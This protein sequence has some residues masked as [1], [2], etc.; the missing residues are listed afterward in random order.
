MK[1]RLLI[2]RFFQ[3]TGSS[4]DGC[5]TQRGEQP[6][7]A[8]FNPRCSFL[9]FNC[10]MSDTL[11]LG[12]GY[13]H[14]SIFFFFFFFFFFYGPVSWRKGEILLK[15][16]LCPSLWRETAHHGHALTVVCN[17]ASLISWS[18]SLILSCM[19][20]SVLYLLRENLGN[21]SIFLSRVK[22]LHHRDF[23]VV[24]DPKLCVY[25]PSDFLNFALRSSFLY[26]NLVTDECWSEY[27]SSNWQNET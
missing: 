27:L 15:S 17:G 16:V 10:L 3:E 14:V 21:H 20:F 19:D 7:L 6:W 5:V 2:R 23:S 12:R 13:S 1:F 4:Y 18:C 11:S 25:F 22:S 9:P 24:F 8:H 26:C